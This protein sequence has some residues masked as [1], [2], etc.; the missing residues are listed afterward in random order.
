MRVVENDKFEVREVYMGLVFH[1]MDKTETI[2][3]VQNTQGVEYDITSTL[4]K[5]SSIGMKK[6][7]SSIPKV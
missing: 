7:P 4:K 1:Y 3:V 6:S 5:I 2:P